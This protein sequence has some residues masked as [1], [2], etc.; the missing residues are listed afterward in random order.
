MLLNKFILLFLVTTGFVCCQ[1]KEKF[2]WEIGISAP[3]YYS[4]LP[5]VKF[6]YKEKQVNSV[7]SDFGIDPGWGE[8]AGGYATGMEE[9]EV[10]D[11]LY[12]N[13]DCG[14][15]MVHYEGTFKLPRTKMV[16]LFNNPVK[17]YNQL[18]D[19]SLIVVGTAPGGNIT[20]WMRAGSVLTE[21]VKYKAKEI[22]KIDPYDKDRVTLWTS[23][24]KE[25]KENFRYL[26]LHGIPYKVWEEGEK[27]YDY[28]VGF[29]SEGN[30]IFPNITTLY[31]KDGSWRQVFKSERNIYEYKWNSQIDSSV[32]NSAKLPVQIEIQWKTISNQKINR[33]I[34][35]L[36]KNFQQVFL[37]EMGNDKKIVFKIYDN[38]NVGSIYL[39]DSKKNMK[40]MD[41]IMKD[42]DDETIKSYYSLPKDFEFPKWEGRENLIKPDL[43]FWQ[44]K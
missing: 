32:S 3:K 28:D 41:F 21:I 19:Y 7:S 29:M 43:E 42:S 31:A 20:I 37:K 36:P 22:N 24:G 14:V 1:P 40:I 25:A 13:W 18:R 15:D 30:N 12:V 10:P 26:Y 4:S 17:E 6:F 9:D 33:A 38:S 39:Y 16:Q 8:T 11:I 23:T 5:N 2:D 27:E 44:E 34:I 35:V